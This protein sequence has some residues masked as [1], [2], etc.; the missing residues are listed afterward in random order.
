MPQTGC[1]AAQIAV[2]LTKH[3]GGLP[4]P[5][6]HEAKADDLNHNQQATTT[7]S[8]QPSTG[9]NQQSIEIAANP[10]SQMLFSN[11]HRNSS[12]PIFFRFPLPT[13]PP[14]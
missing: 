9:T 3:D 10:A 7:G 13:W 2:G 1:N 4:F 12:G 6:T 5:T 11:Y 8:N 14:R